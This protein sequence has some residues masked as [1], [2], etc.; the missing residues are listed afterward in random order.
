MRGAMRRQLL[1]SVLPIPAAIVLVG[2]AFAGDPAAGKAKAEE[3]CQTCHGMD[4]KATIPMAANISGQQKEY[5]V[6]QLKAYHSGDRKHEQMSIVTKMLTDEDI[7]N[8]A[9]WY[10]S[11]K[12]TIEMPE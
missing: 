5:I 1:F 12:I 4:G 10:S 8:L 3:T 9:E 11:I 2:Q 6:A 7:E